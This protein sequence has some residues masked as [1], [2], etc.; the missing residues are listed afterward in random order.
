MLSASTGGTGSFLLNDTIE[1]P[2]ASNV[3]LGDVDGDQDL[4]VVVVTSGFGTNKLL[5]NDGQGNF[6]D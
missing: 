3:A 4:D 2:F 6:I 1:L 5:L